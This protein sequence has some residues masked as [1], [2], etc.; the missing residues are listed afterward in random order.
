MPLLRSSLTS[1]C[2]LIVACESPEAPQG[3]AVSV[4]AVISGPAVPSSA[5]QVSV[6]GVTYTGLSGTAPLVIAPLPA[7]DHQ[8]ALNGIP[9]HCA[10][11]GEQL[12]TVT[13]VAGDTASA[14]FV[15]Q[16][17]EVAATV[18]VT[19]SSEGQEIDPNGY[20][21]VLD[22]TV[23]GGIST[24]GALTLAALPGAHTL[25][26]SHL[27][28][29]CAAARNPREISLYSGG[30]L[31]ATDFEVSCQQ[32]PPAGRGHEIAFFTDRNGTTSTHGDQIYLMNE[33]GTGVRP[34]PNT[35]GPLTYGSP[36]WN[37][38]GSRLLLTGTDLYVLDL[39]GG[40]PT[41][42]PNTRGGAE[43][44]WSPDGT[45]IAFVGNPDDDPQI[46]V[47]D[48][49]GSNAQLVTAESRAAAPSSPTW[50]PDG[51]RIAFVSQENFEEGVTTGRIVI[52]DLQNTVR[53]T[54]YTDEGSSLRQ[55]AWSPDGTK[56]AFS[57][58]SRGTF[59]DRI[60]VL[61]LTG[62]SGPH[63][64]SSG[65]ED[66][67]PSWSSDG[68][69]IAFAR[70]SLDSTDIYTVNFDGTEEDRI[71]SEPTLDWDPAWRP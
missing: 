12:R 61:D 14:D 39:S 5:L 40:V 17:Q 26:L 30:S 62:N 44:A 48:V 3:G 56:L 25:E 9:V 71:T 43:P 23:K 18:L 55:V 41:P 22:G 2:C 32:A 49:D 53:D 57:G 11:E 54:V 27:T 38:D 36:T 29:N 45:R 47:V 13:V 6:D 51:H 37:P 31:T 70:F 33:D 15:V 1:A 60:Q 66:I 7:G 21:V 68:A 65:E 16:C 28:A 52:L 59:D 69:R 8:L 64:V 63:V 10:V 24:A 67:Q 19:V 46:W 58:P 42:I 4:S 20:Q 34:V 50:A 35:S